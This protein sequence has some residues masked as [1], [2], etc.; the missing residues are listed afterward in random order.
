MSNKKTPDTRCPNC[1][2]EFVHDDAFAWGIDEQG[3]PTIEN[4]WCPACGISNTPLWDCDRCPLRHNCELLEK[5][6]MCKCCDMYVDYSDFE[7]IVRN[8]TEEVDNV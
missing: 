3:H 4:I 8:T 6:E 7:E 2:A 1:K 5:D